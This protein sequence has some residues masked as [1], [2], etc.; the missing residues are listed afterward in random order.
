LDDYAK[1]L[2]E[3]EKETQRL[4]TDIYGSDYTV[5]EYARVSRVPIRETKLKIAGLFAFIGLLIGVG[6]VVLLE[7]LDQTFKTVDDVRD[8]LGLP[9]LGVIPAI[10][11]PRDHRRRLWFRVLAFSSGVFVLGVGVFVYFMVP[12]VQ[13]FL[14]EQVWGSLQSMISSF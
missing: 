2:R 1:G 10:Y 12:E 11:T 3:A 8:I 5:R 9:A 6:L 14:R 4:S 13:D 7:Y